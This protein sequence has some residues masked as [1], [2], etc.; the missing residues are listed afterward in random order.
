MPSPP[1][2]PLELAIFEAWCRQNGLDPAQL[3]RWMAGTEQVSREVAEGLR[4]VLGVPIASWK[5]VEPKFGLGTSTSGLNRVPS[6]PNMSSMLGQESTDSRALKIAKKRTEGRKRHPAVEA[7]YKAGHT[8]QSAAEL[9][10]TTRDVLK[11]AW[12]KGKQFREI[13]PE[14]KSRLAKEGIPASVWPTEPGEK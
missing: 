12:G 14:W 9:C 8:P 13:R 11:Q 3:R 5:L 1:R 6:R 4:A 2:H 7:I 10:G